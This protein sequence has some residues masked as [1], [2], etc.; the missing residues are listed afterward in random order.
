MEKLFDIPQEGMISE[1]NN[2]HDDFKQQVIW[3][4]TYLFPVLVKGGFLSEFRAGNGVFNERPIHVI[5][6]YANFY[7]WYVE[8][9]SDDAIG[10]QVRIHGAQSAI[11]VIPAIRE[12]FNDILDYPRVNFPKEVKKYPPNQRIETMLSFLGIMNIFTLVMLT[13]ERRHIPPRFILQRF[14]NIPA[15]CW[16]LNSRNKSGNPDRMVMNTRGKHALRTMTETELITKLTN[17]LK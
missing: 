3:I 5:K 8:N 2:P 13:N 6:N 16:A 14:D 15:S 17:L 7:N 1:K 9:K 12:D 11:T 4:C 10:L